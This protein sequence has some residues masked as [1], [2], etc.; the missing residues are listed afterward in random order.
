MWEKGK[1]QRWNQLFF[2]F[3][4]SQTNQTLVKLFWLSS[5]HPLCSIR[6]SSL[7]ILNTS[8]SPPVNDDPP[9][10]FFTYPS[11]F[12]CSSPLVASHSAF[13]FNLLPWVWLQTTA[14]LL[15]VF[16]PWPYQLIWFNYNYMLMITKDV[17]VHLDI[18]SNFKLYREAPAGYA[19]RCL[20]K[21]IVLKIS[22]LNS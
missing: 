15:P 22:K 10:C 5:N 1:S 14:P 2:F 3:G 17:F 12:S 19:I 13:F 20:P 18:H 21:H 4:L 16:W 8:Y 9:L 11:N 6:I 7:F